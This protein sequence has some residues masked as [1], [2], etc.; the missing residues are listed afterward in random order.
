MRE[1]MLE[2]SRQL[3][4]TCNYCHDVKNFRNESMKTWKIS[5]EHMHIV[6]LLNTRGFTKGP[7]ADCYMCHRGKATPDYK[8]GLPPTSP[9]SPTSPTA[10]PPKQ[11]H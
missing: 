1:Y 5:K 6:Q 4:V 8:E 2:I 9:L 11:T 7:K 10:E 3:G